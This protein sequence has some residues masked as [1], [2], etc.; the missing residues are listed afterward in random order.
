MFQITKIKIVTIAEDSF[1]SDNKT[2]NIEII[3]KL[4]ARKIVN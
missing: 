2:K 4:E 1:L 3:Q